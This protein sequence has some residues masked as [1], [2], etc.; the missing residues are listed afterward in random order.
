MAHNTQIDTAPA[1]QLNTQKLDAMIVHWAE[2]ASRHRVSPLQRA[3]AEGHVSALQ[4]MRIAH[5]L[6]PLEVA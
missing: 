3:I 2:K 6:P 5:D 1:L 4:M